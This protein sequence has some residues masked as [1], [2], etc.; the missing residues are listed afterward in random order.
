MQR[1]GNRT[2]PVY[3]VIHAA[4]ATS[5]PAHSRHPL[6]ESLPATNFSDLEAEIVEA[7]AMD[8]LYVA[9]GGLQSPAGITPSLTAAFGEITAFMIKHSIEMQSQPMA[10]TRGWDGE[11]HAFLA[12]VP[13][14]AAVPAPGGTIQAGTSPSG[15]AVRVTA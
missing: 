13:V 10:I 9:A 14:S 2:S 3:L 1:T 6:S 15:R 11:D 5:P 8:I 4:P 12:A 7:E